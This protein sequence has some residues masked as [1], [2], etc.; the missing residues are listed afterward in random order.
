[1]FKKNFLKNKQILIKKKLQKKIFLYKKKN[2]ETKISCFCYPCTWYENFGYYNLKFNYS[3]KKIYTFFKYLYFFA[4]DIFLVAIIPSYNIYINKNSKKKS[5]TLLITWGGK[6]NFNSKGIYEDRKFSNI[7]K[8]K[9]LI[10]A[11]DNLQ[12]SKYRNQDLVIYRKNEKKFFV[13]FLLKSILVFLYKNNFSIINF[14]HYFNIY[15]F[16][17]IWF[18]EKIM[19]YVKENKINCLKIN[20]EGQPYQNYFINLVKKYN[21]DI[22]IEAY[23]FATQP[24]PL[25]LLYNNQKIDKIYVYDQQVKFQLFKRLGW[26]K[27]KIKFL[28]KKS[29]KK[30]I[31][32]NKIFI[33]YGVHDPKGMLMSFKKLI[34]K[35]KMSF[36]KEEVTVLF[37]ILLLE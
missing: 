11:S 15:T 8:Y 34:Y 25:H 13:F 18:T 37:T 17:S 14:L 10:I 36:K 22:K 9:N 31:F 4:K 3:S 27:E 32:K 35:E 7:N 28:K 23:I 19:K 30:R 24:L 16:Y 29:I 20:F 21:P 2:I 12:G 26:K 33:G 5:K 1:M 6:E